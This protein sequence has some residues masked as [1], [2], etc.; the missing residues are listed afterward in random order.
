MY[1]MAWIDIRYSV[2]PE[3]QSTP[4]GTQVLKL[5]LQGMCEGLQR[6]DSSFICVLILR[7]YRSSA[8][9][10]DFQLL[11]RSGQ[12][13]KQTEAASYSTAKRVRRCRT[14]RRSTVDDT[15]NKSISFVGDVGT[16]RP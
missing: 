9:H 16:I 5:S 4:P 13:L 6:R 15:Y 3:K 14:R 10:S 7:Q 12:R 1:R 2:Q 8:I 11:C